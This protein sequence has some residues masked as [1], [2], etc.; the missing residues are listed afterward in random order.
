VVILTDDH[1]FADMHCQGQVSDIQTPNIDRLA[2][3]GVRFSD[4]YVTAPQCCPSRAGLL[5][6]RY[7]QRFGLD[8]NGKC[9]LPLEE[10]TIADRLKVAGCVTG[11]VGKWH[12]EPNVQ[13]VAWAKANPDKASI[14]PDGKVETPWEQVLSYY[15]QNRGFSEFFK[16][17]MKRYWASYALDGTNLATGGEWVQTDRYRLDVQ[18]DAAVAFIDRHPSEPFFL[19]LA[20]Y[21][22]HTPLE[23]TADRLARFPGDMPERRRH[24]LAM[25]SAID[26]GVGRILEA[27]TRHGID[28]DTLVFF[29]SDNG[30]PLKLTKEDSPVTG[31]A[32]GWDGSLNEPWLGEKG[33][34][35]EGG[36][37]V[38]FLARWKGVLPGGKTFSEPVISLDIA[39]TAVG[40]AGLDAPPEL[41]GVNLLPY[42]TGEKE[43]APHEA[44]YWRFWTQGAVRRGRWK[45]VQVG[46]RTQYLFDLADRAHENRDVLS[47]NPEVA[48]S[49][50]KDLDA[51]NVSLK[52]PEALS[53][54]HNTQEARFYNHY[55]GAGL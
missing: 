36:I 39:A 35:T 23:A 25:I 21:A 11:M 10:I 19:Y 24:A 32:G 30:A 43:G 41:D 31:D 3:E 38:P 28:E 20:Y 14:R 6:G 55:L 29:L 26:D 52:T 40:A 50:H 22:P 54:K 7:Q 49:L 47:A 13:S 8:E 45:Y 5:T 2:A 15:P 48:A 4:G 37:H 34:L 33:M 12:L 16:G 18:S 1:G 46:E 9:P 27:L 44:L 53:G 51:W 42:L 17:E